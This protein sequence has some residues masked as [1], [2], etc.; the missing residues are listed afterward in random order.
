M[1]HAA[2]DV[3]RLLACIN[4]LLGVLPRWFLSA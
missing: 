2:D 4:D 1:D 3:T